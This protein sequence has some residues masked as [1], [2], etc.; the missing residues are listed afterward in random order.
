METLPSIYQHVIQVKV[1]ENLLK[2]DITNIYVFA[3]RITFK[4]TFIFTCLY[5]Y[6]SNFF[7]F[8][9]AN[10]TLHITYSELLAIF[11]QCFDNVV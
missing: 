9:K 4:T 2:K 1:N 10:T 3:F 8:S 11:R 6:N 5:F 7:F